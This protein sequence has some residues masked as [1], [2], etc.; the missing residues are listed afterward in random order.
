MCLYIKSYCLNQRRIDAAAQTAGVEDEEEE[1]EL[2]SV[3]L[4]IINHLNA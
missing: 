1:E 2:A 3:V 4:L